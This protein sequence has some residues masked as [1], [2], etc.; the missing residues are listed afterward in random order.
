MTNEI[1]LNAECNLWHDKW[2]CEKLTSFKIMLVLQASITDDYEEI[3]FFL[4]HS[5]ATWYPPKQQ[6]NSKLCFF[7]KGS[8]EIRDPL[9]ILASIQFIVSIQIKTSLI[10]CTTKKGKVLP[11]KLWYN[12][13]SH[14]IF[15]LYSLKWCF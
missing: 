4:P 8:L 1:L 2:W 5:W 11:I 14:R 3:S 12:V 13:W 6:R 10:V 9:P 7:T 15:V